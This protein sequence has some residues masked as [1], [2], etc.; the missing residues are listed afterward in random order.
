MVVPVRTL[1]PH[2]P[3]PVPFEDGVGRGPD[4]ELLAGQGVP[5]GQTISYSDAFRSRNT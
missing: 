2:E 3:C 5:D 4:A 1:A